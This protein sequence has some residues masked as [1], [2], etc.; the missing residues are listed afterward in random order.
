MTHE[1]VMTI[2][3]TMNLPYAY[4]HFSEGKSPEPPFIIFSLPRS[5]NFAADGIVYHHVSKLNIELY[6]EIKNPNLELTVESIFNTN[7]VFFNKSEVWIK[8]E[9]LYE[10]LYEMEV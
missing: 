4:D 6:T 2:I 1:E 9:Q 3:T 10:V 5:A 8:E 7:G